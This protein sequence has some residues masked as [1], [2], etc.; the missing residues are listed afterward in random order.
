MF[1]GQWSDLS[2]FA[3]NSFSSRVSNTRLMCSSP[4]LT[5]YI[6]FVY[7]AC[8]F[9]MCSVHITTQTDRQTDRQTD[10]YVK[11]VEVYIKI[12]VPFVDWNKAACQNVFKRLTTF[13]L[14][15][16]TGNYGGIRGTRYIVFSNCTQTDKP[17]NLQQPVYCF[18]SLYA[19]G[20]PLTFAASGIFSH[21]T[22]TDKPWHLKQ[23]VHC[24]QSL[25]KSDKPWHLQH[26]VYC[27]QSLYTVGQTLTFVA[28]GI[29]SHFTQT[30]KPWHL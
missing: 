26:P 7:A 6:W 9:T 8:Q 17:W 2:Y 18:Q 28:S 13:S 4:S 25:Y 14:A 24:F 22:Q 30:D 19:V 21:R 3:C 5:R 16:R 10:A 1:R 29:F 12:S 20:Q 11:L 15:L 23:S 27:F